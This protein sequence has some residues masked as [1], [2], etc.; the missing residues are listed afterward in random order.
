MIK[1]GKMLLYALMSVF[2]IEVCLWFFAGM[3]YNDTN[4]VASGGNHSALF[5]ALVSTSNSTTTSPTSGPPSL[6]DGGF[7]T[8]MLAIIS[9]SVLAGIIA[10]FYQSSNQWVLFAVGC[11]LLITYVGVIV[12]LWTFLNNALLGIASATEFAGL[13]SSLITA[14]LIILYITSLVEWSRFNQ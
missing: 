8:I 7:W 4:P 12:Q 14:P 3:G 5:S 6:F 2:I 10:T 9:V 11:S 1:M 13:I